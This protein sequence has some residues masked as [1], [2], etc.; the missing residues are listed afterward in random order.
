EF[1]VRFK[2]ESS[3]GSAVTREWMDLVAMEAFLNPEKHLLV[4]FDGNST[5]TLDPLGPFINPCWYHD[6]ELLGRLIGLALYHNISINVPLHPHLC[7]LLFS[8]GELWPDWC[9]ADL[10]PLDPGTYLHKV[11]WLVENDVELLG[12]ELTFTDVLHTP[13]PAKPKPPAA[14][15]EKQEGSSSSSP[16]AS[17]SALASAQEQ[18]EEE[19]SDNQDEDWHEAPQEFDPLRPQEWEDMELPGLVSDEHR[20]PGDAMDAAAGFKRFDAC[21][22]LVD[23]VENGD[24]VL[25]TNEN[26]AA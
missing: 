14:D 24:Q 25:V 11:K 10:E 6:Y 20:L 19:D 18:Q 21:E 13:P 22:S 4:S 5:F 16:G 8:G 1:E 17:T 9:L 26:K 12:F 7:R 15:N 3:A 2:G 23:L